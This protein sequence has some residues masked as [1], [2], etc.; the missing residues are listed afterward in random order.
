MSNNELIEQIVKEVLK[1]MESIQ[2]DEQE[3]KSEES[4]SSEVV[5]KKDYPLGKKRPEL[6]K[7]S[8]GKSIEDINLEN[9]LSEKITL[10]DIKMNSKTLLYQ[11]EIA[12][13][14]GNVQLAANFRRAAELTVVPDD[15]VLE[16]YD[17]LKPYKST[18]Q[19]LIE[20]AEELEDK[21]NA[22]LNAKLVREAVESYEKRN[23]IKM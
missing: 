1:S 3:Y 22:K 8:T 18:K 2:N 15:R 19:Q 4:Y 6:I 21:Y 11:A 14:I 17:A 12:E 9:V 23:M 16:I 10:E 7:T 20:I 13:S 5:N